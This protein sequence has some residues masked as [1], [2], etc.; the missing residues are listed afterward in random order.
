MRLGVAL[1]LT[2][3]IAG[4]GLAC[5]SLQDTR[6]EEQV[7]SA[8]SSSDHWKIVE[9]YRAEA[10]QARKKSAQHRRLAGVYGGPQREGM[11]FA[12]HAREHCNTLA[13]SEDVIAAQYD[14]LAAEHERLAQE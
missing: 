8:Q 6:I 3:W 9:Y 2:A 1:G 10:G 7:R 14:L 5:A 13:D 4:A 11:V 12:E